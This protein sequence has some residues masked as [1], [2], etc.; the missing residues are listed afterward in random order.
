MNCRS[1]FN[2]IFGGI[3]MRKWIWKTSNDIDKRNKWSIKF[4]KKYSFY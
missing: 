4:N 3:L 2:R 1:L